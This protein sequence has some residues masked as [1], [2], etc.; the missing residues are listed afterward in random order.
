MKFTQMIAALVVV[1]LFAP[2][3]EAR[4][5]V[6]RSILKTFF[7]KGDRPTQQQFATLIDSTINIVEDRHLLGL[8]VYDPTISY[9]VQRLGINEP[10]PDTV[11]GYSL[12]T[13]SSL[14]QMEPGFAGQ[15]GFAALLYGDTTG[16]HY[17]GFMQVQ[18]EPLTPT[19]DAISP[20]IFVSYVV[21]ET[22]PNL[23]FSTFVVPEPT[24]VLALG[25]GVFAIGRRSRRD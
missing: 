18:M 16:N 2:L 12:P 5:K 20:G 13:P 19:R 9:A 25:A 3:A 17:Y 24:S 14:L 8:K 22:T 1:S 7:E 15:F 4:P 21:L 11:L 10:I 6:A 23:S